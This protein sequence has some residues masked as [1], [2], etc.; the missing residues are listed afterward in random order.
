MMALKKIKTGKTN[1]PDINHL[2]M[3]VAHTLSLSTCMADLFVSMVTTSHATGLEKTLYLLIK[4]SLVL[5]W[6]RSCTAVPDYD[7]A[8][9]MHLPH[10]VVHNFPKA[11]GVQDLCPL[12]TKR[13]HISGLLL[14]YLIGEASDGPIPQ[15][16]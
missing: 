8:C 2:M 11:V 7:E 13:S 16:D 6:A 14:Q 5:L 1:V 4:I 9:K 10:E 3:L 12:C 15:A